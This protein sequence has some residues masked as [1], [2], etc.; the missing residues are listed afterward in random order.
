M[1]N[2]QGRAACLADEQALDA[3]AAL[4]GLVEGAEDELGHDGLQLALPEVLHHARRVAAKLLTH[5]SQSK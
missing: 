4:A 1:Q 5:T 2:I 3:D